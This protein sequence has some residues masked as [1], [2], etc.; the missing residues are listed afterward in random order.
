[1]KV[2]LKSVCIVLGILILAAFSP[3]PSRPALG[4]ELQPVLH[5][6]LC[7]SCPDYGKDRD[8][9]YSKFS[10]TYGRPDGRDPGKVRTAG[11]GLIL[12]RIRKALFIFLESALHIL[13]S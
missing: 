1:M 13:A 7:V 2:M 10:K 5:W 12:L 4:H 9:G 6:F 11:R 8:F 3:F